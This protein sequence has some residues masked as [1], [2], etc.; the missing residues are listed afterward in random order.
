MS[1]H[2]RGKNWE[3]S[4]NKTLLKKQ[5]TNKKK[6]KAKYILQKMALKVNS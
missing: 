1:L 5:R 3:L 4:L 2:T 6:V